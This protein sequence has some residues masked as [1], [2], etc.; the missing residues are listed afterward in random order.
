MTRFFRCISCVAVVPIFVSAC[1]APAPPPAAAPAP[2]ERGKYIVDTAGCHD[3]DT[4]AKMGP[5]GPEPD[6]ARARSGHPESVKV[7]P[8]P[9]VIEPTTP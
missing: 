4:P 8:D 9:I 2:I 3:C 1:A 7:V 6:M 5:N